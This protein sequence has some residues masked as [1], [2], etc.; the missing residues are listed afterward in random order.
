MPGFN[1]V[2]EPW[3]PCLFPKGDIDALGLFEVLTRSHEIREIFDPSPL[4]VTALHRL[5]LAILHRNFGPETLDDWKELWQRGR[6]DEAK[7][8]DYFNRWRHRFDLF[9]PD[10]P[11][12][13][14]PK[15]DGAIE[16]PAHLLLLE[17]SAGNNPTLFDHSFSTAPTTFTPALAARALLARQAYSIGFGKSKP[18][19][20]KDSTLIRGYSILTLGNNLWETLALNLVAYNKERPIPHSG[21]DL[22]VWEKESLPEPDEK[23]NRI[24]GYVD[25]LTWQSRGIHLLPEGNPPVVHRCQIQQNLMLPKPLPLDPFKSYIPDR[26]EGWR[27]RGLVPDRAVWRDSHSLFQVAD[28]TQ[29]Q[30]EVFAW[31]G[32]IWGLKNAG[33]IS[34]QETYGFLAVGLATDIGKAANIL[35]WRQE[36]LPLPLVYLQDVENLLGKLKDALDLA[37]EASRIL[38]LHLRVMA[39]AIWDPKTDAER[40]MRD[41]ATTIFAP[42]IS[43][44]LSGALFSTEVKNA[45]KTWA[46]ARLFFSQLEAP[47]RRLLVELPEDLQEDEEGEIEYGSRNIPTWSLMLR[48]AARGALETIAADLGGSPRALKAVAQVEGHFR[49]VLNKKI[50][51]G[52]EYESEE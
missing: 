41:I 13:Q 2:D 36:R 49:W 47:F 30:P 44:R 37:E 45:L 38:E 4:V 15:M 16:H 29:R 32:R 27:P 23:G 20:F 42:E 19:Y 28:Q 48:H 50:S 25:Y 21:D 43:K 26:E 35:F 3:V 51:E 31:A 22:P 34:A 14:V 9:H 12:Y 24:Q 33:E 18:F 6:W 40:H 39:L 17:A 52:G 7:L 8:G 1:L 10:R 5:L 11:F 46:P